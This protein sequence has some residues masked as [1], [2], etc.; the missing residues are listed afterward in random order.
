VIELRDEFGT[1]VDPTPQLD[2]ERRDRSS[3]GR[4]AIMNLSAWV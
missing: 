2:D 3:V 1:G 4:C